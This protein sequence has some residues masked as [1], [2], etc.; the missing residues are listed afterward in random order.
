MDINTRTQVIILIFGIIIG[1][2]GYLANSLYLWN[3]SVNKEKSDIALG[4][5]LD[6]SALEEFLTT[7]DKEF[8]S[9]PDDKYIFIL[10]TPFYRDNGLYFSYQQDIFKLDRKTA[11]DTFLFYSH[12]LSAERDRNVIYSIQRLSDIRELTSPELTRQQTLTRNVGREVN[13][14]VGLLPSL[15]SE[16]DNA[17]RYEDSLLNFLP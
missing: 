5:F 17:T 11:M 16:L 6:V 1:A 15:K 3:T 7:A 10:A 12:L 9:N 4:L 2:S 8:L 13:I 14:S